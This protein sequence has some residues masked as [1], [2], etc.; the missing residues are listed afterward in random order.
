M[1]IL[2]NEYERFGVTMKH[3][4]KNVKIIGCCIL[5]VLL[6]VCGFVIFHKKSPKIQLTNELK[7]ELRS[8]IPTHCGGYDEELY[9][10]KKVSLS[11]L[12]SKS[13]EDCVSKEV[14]L[15]FY[16]E[17]EWTVKKNKVYLKD[18]ILIYSISGEGENK[19]HWANQYNDFREEKN[20]QLKH[21]DIISPEDK[22]FEQYGKVYQYTFE[23]KKDSFELISIEE[24]K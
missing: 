6:I 24:V 9:Q 16:Q 17:K 7:Q 18:I 19:V 8:M 14:H 3:M 1:L 2:Y 11:D 15:T 12:S 21:G 20:V 23:K 5:L 13:Q 10:N 4:K 22:S